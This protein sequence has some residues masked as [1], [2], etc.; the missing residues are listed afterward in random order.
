MSL[1]QEIDSR[2][3]EIIAD[4]YPM[5]IGELI[6]LYRDGELNLHP[7]FQ[8]QYRWGLSQKSKLIESILIGIPLPSIFVSQRESDNVW[9]VIDGLQRLSTIFEF[10]GCLKDEQ[11]DDRPPLRLEGTRYLPSLDG[12]LWEGNPAHSL[13]Q[14]QRVLI[15]RAKIDIKIIKPGSSDAS[16]FE[17]FYRLNKLGATATDQEVRNCLLIMANRALFRELSTLAN[18]VDFRTCTALSDRQID[19]QY[20]LEL[21]LRFLLLKDIDPSS[22]RFED[23]GEVLTN[24]M[25]ET[26]VDPGFDLNAHANAFRRT[27]RLL[28]ESG[29]EDDSFRRYEPS[30]GKFMGGFTISAFEVIALGIGHQVTRTPDWTPKTPLVE[31]VK[32]LWS[33]PEFRASGGSGVAAS[34]R[35]PRT[36]PLGR[37]WF[38]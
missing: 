6:N 34:T 15:K 10:V 25:L 7:E 11:G 16:R 35:I 9:E 28:A 21:V 30:R 20:N 13:T 29:L 37:K 36:L 3:K 19:E 8:R 38:K 5:S 22:R 2:A 14:N 1:Q 32:G 18:E 4:G 27:F 17:M 12:K 33:D 23:L 26:A 24:L 31:L